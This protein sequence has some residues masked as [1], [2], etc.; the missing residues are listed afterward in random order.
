MFVSVSFYNIIY[1]FVLMTQQVFFLYY[2]WT[3]ELV[4]RWIMFKEDY[5]P[6][7]FC[8]QSYQKMAPSF[9]NPLTAP[10]LNP[11]GTPTDQNTGRCRHQ[12]LFGSVKPAAVI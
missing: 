2:K 7:G 6:A 12:L 5:F 1:K 10:H 3:K 4:K 11:D 9:Q 8:F